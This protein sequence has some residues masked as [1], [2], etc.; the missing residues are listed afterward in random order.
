[1]AKSAVLKLYL[2]LSGG[3]DSGL[4]ELDVLN[5]WRKYAVSGDMHG[6][7]PLLA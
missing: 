5:D 7:P 6:G 3:V 4:N 1:M 2:H